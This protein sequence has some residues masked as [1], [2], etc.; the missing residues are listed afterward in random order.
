MSIFKETLADSIQ[1]QLK[2]RTLVISG[3]GN[4]KDPQLPWYLSKTAW[5]RMTSFVNFNEGPTITSG[6]EWESGIIKT[7]TTKGNYK[8]DELSRK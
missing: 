1:T 3:E 8:D 2:A 6:P 4:Q 5:V 7:D